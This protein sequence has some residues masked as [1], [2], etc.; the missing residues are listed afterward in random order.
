M[1]SA[2]R[3]AERIRGGAK[4]RKSTPVFLVGNMET[5]MSWYRDIGFE[6]H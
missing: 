2:Q 1:P 4:L 3:A 5:T 6:T